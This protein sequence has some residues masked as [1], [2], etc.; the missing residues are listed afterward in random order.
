M[1]ELGNVFEEHKLSH[2]RIAIVHRK[3]NLNIIKRIIASNLSPSLVVNPSLFKENFTLLDQLM[4]FF[5][6]FLSAIEENE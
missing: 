5:S 1:I 2:S 6:H 3:I 4:S